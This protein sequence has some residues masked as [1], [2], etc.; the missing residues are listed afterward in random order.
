MRDLPAQRRSEQGIALI[1]VLIF[2][3][4]LYAIVADLVTT[5]RTARLVGE[6]ASLIARMDNHMSYCLSQVEELLL[7]DLA[8]AAAAGGGDGGGAAGGGGGIPGLGGLGG[9]GGAGVPGDGG[10]GDDEETEASAQCDGSQDA[11][12]EPTAYADGDITTYVWVED[13]NAK[14]N[15]LTLVSPDQE[16]AL[17]SRERFVR[18][19]DVL[20][21]QT[22][23]DLTR[24][25]G[26]ALADTI[27]DWFNSRIRTEEMPR[28]QLKTDVQTERSEVSLPLHLD[29]LLLLRNVD[30]NLFY[31]KVLDGELIH[32]LESV[33]TV[34]TSLAFDPGQPD[35]PENQNSGPD[36]DN[37]TP[38]GG[39]PNAAG[40]GSTGTPGEPPDEPQGIGI[41]INI[42]T[43]PRPVLRCLF[44]SAEMSDTVLDAILKWRNEPVEEEGDLFGDGATPQDDYLGVVEEGDTVKLQVFTGTDQLE[45]IEEFAN[46]A[47]PTVKDR[48]L[49]LIGTNSDV[50][51]IHMASIFVR[52]EEKRMHVQRRKRSVMVRLDDGEDGTLHPLILHE[53]RRGLRVKGKDFYDTESELDVFA[54]NE[55]MDMFSQEE[56]AWNP[57]LLD[58]YLPEE[59]RARLG[60]TYR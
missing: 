5:A 3:I 53:K 46:M 20:R 60:Y 17:E 41:L 8:A 4:L 42:N 58:F 24:S 36:G 39:D 55:Q 37:Q 56:K 57:F 35:D 49:E 1:L 54:R 50:F 6:N 2:T 40:G 21:D 7:G 29:E 30:D 22:D 44:S 47:D 31:D 43:A 18:L 32:G 15:L 51:S 11:W 52:N 9:A 13:E 45:E 23:F 59:Q 19:I 14:F 10:D 12:Y 33:L 28:P 48:F 25:D 26:E 34:H 38:D 16:F 27:L